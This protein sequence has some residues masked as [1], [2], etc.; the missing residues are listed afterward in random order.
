[1]EEK[2]TFKLLTLNVWHGG[3]VMEN[4]LDFL[5]RENADVMVFQEINS[6]SNLSLPASYHTS[7][8]LK[9]LFPDYDLAFDSGHKI[10]YTK[11][12]IQV[13][14]GNATLSRFPIKKHELQY[15]DSEYGV[16]D[17]PSRGV[18]QDY[19]HYP[20]FMQKSWLKI[21]GKTVLVI[22]L[23]GVW[24]FHGF[25][26]PERLAMSRDILAATKGEEYVIIAGDSNA[27]W[28]TETIRNLENIYPNVFKTSLVSTFNMKRK[29]NGG[30]ASAAV[31]ILLTSPNIK[32]IS[33]GCPG[34]DVSD[35]LPLT[36]ILEI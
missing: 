33:S 35:H 13:E 6:H 7:T 16:F 4:L 3:I 5:A 19:R 31:D 23:H 2:V 17:S 18:K 26:T 34:V 22:N 11:E 28:E 32:V 9:K 29:S 1:M 12:Q 21:A 14:Q 24:D 8:E 25:D 20:K 10:N 30:Y 36:A 27:K 15:F